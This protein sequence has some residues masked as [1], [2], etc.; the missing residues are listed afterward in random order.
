MPNRS[1]ARVVHLRDERELRGFTVWCLVRLAI[2]IG[3]AHDRLTVL[4]AYRVRATG[5][6]APRGVHTVRATTEEITDE[7]Q[8]RR[9]VFGRGRGG[10]V[11]ERAVFEHLTV[12]LIGTRVGAEQPYSHECDDEQDQRPLQQSEKSG[13]ASPQAVAPARDAGMNPARLAFPPGFYLWH[14]FGWCIVLR[15]FAWGRTFSRGVVVGH[16][17]LLCSGSSYRSAATASVALAHYKFKHKK[18]GHD[19]DSRRYHARVQVTSFRR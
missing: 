6:V 4:E 14:G 10:D 2:D 16:D 12:G 1:V 9:H 18:N 7:R 19:L 15:P 8:L 5:D 11:C 13:A 3:V 17:E